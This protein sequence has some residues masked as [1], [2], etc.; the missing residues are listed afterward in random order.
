M[1]RS[2]VPWEESEPVSEKQEY[3]DG[4]V[5]ARGYVLDYHKVLAEQDLDALRAI[6]GLIEAVYL[7]ERRLDRKTKELLFVLSLT[8]MRSE[9][10]HIK[11]HIQAALDAG[12][13]EEEVL[14][15]IEISLPEAG[16]VAFQHGFDAWKEVTGATGLEPTV[17]AYE[18]SR[19]E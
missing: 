2:G 9:K 3:L 1:R 17:E 13:S 16:V 7:K 14:E 4:L 19:N 8:V 6:N 5:R 10:G 11:S 15:A 18:G 12:A